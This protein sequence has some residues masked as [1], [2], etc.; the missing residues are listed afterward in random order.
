MLKFIALVAALAGALSVAGHASANSLVLSIEPLIEPRQIF[1]DARQI[2][3]EGTITSGSADQLKA[4]LEENRVP[5]RS[6]IYLHS[7]GG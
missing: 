2:F 6:T 4:F 7:P 1:G 5:A 3:V